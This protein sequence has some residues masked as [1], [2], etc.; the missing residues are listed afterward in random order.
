MFK[1]D[2]LL[3]NSSFKIVNFPLCEARL[4]DNQYFPWFLL[5]PKVNQVTEIFQLSEL[6]RKL[7]MDEVT[8]VSRA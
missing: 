1:L 7:L 5:I 6:N 8:Q 3:E 2:S 4:K